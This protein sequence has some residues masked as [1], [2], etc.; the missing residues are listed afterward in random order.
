M[1]YQRIK[2]KNVSVGQRQQVMQKWMSLPTVSFEEFTSA[3]TLSLRTKMDGFSAEL[4]L[5]DR[6]E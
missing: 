3:D 2:E 5:I 4:I 1:T 6:I